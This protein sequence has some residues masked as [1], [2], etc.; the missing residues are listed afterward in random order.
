MDGF[1]AFRT[2]RSRPHT[3]VIEIDIGGMTFS[4]TSNDI[5]NNN[6]DV[7][8]R[9]KLRADMLAEQLDPPD[10]F[11]H[12]NPDDTVAIAMNVNPWQ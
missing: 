11:V 2:Y 8:L 10:F 3:N 4:A 9:N 6:S 12:V 1:T 5:A 7:S